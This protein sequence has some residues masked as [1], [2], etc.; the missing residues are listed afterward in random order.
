M[1]SERFE[2]KVD[3]KWGQHRR[4]RENGHKWAGIALL[5]V[6]GLLLARESGMFFPHWFF[7]WPMV[8]IG[9]GLFTGI[10]HQFNSPVPFI[11]LVVGGI[12]LAGEISSEYSLRQYLWPAILITMGLVFIFRSRRFGKQGPAEGNRD[13]VVTGEDQQQWEEAMKS[14]QDVIDVTAIF[15]GVKKNILTKQFKG[16][17]IVTFMGG[18]DINLTQTDFQGKVIIDCF[19]MFGGTKLIVPADW[20]VQSQVVAIFGGVDDKRPPAASVDPNKVLFL[21]GTCLFGGVEIR[22]F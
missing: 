12:F 9:I 19:N 17:E 1:N 5:I 15:G 20:D 18:A 4:H 2:D 7:T 21:D 8:L 16:G 3:R 22:S 14:R 10:R 6:G 13:I 11:L